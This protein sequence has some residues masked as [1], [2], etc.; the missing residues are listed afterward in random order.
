M[1]IVRILD[2]IL[3]QG[4]Q[5]V[6]ITQLGPQLFEDDPIPLLTL[7]SDFLFEVI[8]EIFC[9]PI[10]VQQRVIDIKQKHHV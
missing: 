4:A 8:R 1:G 10:V 9:D 5:I 7:M 2:A 3:L 6:C